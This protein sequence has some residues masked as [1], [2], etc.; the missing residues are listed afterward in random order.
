MGE[1]H[2]GEASG[3]EGP[4]EAKSS[5][6]HRPSAWPLRRVPAA[7]GGGLGTGVVSS[8]SASFLPATSPELLFILE[9]CLKIV[10]FVSAALFTG[11]SSSSFCKGSATRTFPSKRKPGPDERPRRHDLLFLLAPPRPGGD[12]RHTDASPGLG[13]GRSR[14]VPTF[15]SAGARS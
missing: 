4:Q 7:R 15:S 6:G 10:R 3:T 1:R 14:A 2:S 5:R 9:F 11:L 12:S 13:H 8:P